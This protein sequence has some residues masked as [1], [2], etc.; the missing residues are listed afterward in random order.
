LGQKKT[1]LQGT[2]GKGEKKKKKKGE[3]KVLRSKEQPAT[4]VYFSFSEIVFVG[5]IIR[6]W[7]R[8]LRAVST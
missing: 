2:S 7:A 8:H 4:P 1:V 3:E 6:P 5:S